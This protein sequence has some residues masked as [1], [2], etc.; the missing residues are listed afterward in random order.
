MDKDLTRC[1]NCLLFVWTSGISFNKDGICNLCANWLN[2]IK[3]R[4][5]HIKKDSINN[6]VNKLRQLGKEKKYDCL[7]GISGGI[8]SA[9]LLSILVN[10]HNL[11]CLAAYYK[12]PFTPETID[13]NVKR[14]VNLLKVPLIEINLARD[15]HKE[16]ARDFVIAW[17]KTKDP[18]FANLACAPCKLL[19]RELFMIAN[20]Y[21]I[22]AVVHGDNRYEHTVVAA[23]QFLSDN[24]NRY[25]LIFNLLRIL[26]ILKRGFGLLWKYPIVFRNISLLFRASILYLNPYTA[27]FRIRYPN[28]FVFNY[29][30][31]EDWD[32]NECDNALKNVGWIL[33]HGCNSKKKSDCTFAEL[34]NIMFRESIGAGYIDFM[35]SNLIRYGKISREEGLKRLEKEGQVSI[36]RLDET[37]RI[38]NLSDNLF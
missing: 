35:I 2:N 12:T 20:K 4:K 38:L 33:P 25:S 32:E 6:V 14:M 28:I 36:H 11:R 1:K 19:H 24:K 18:I 31:H 16:V 9:Y 17:K 29:F 23:G 5:F 7:V 26:L 22:P 21:N 15:Y 10:K 30:N 8:D 3:S 37:C 27:Y 13:D 34:K